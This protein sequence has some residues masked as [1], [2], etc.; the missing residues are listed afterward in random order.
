[1]VLDLSAGEKGRSAHFSPG[2]LTEQLWTPS[3]EGGGPEPGWASP[4]CHQQLQTEKTD[5]VWGVWVDRRGHRLEGVASEQNMRVGLLEKTAPGSFPGWNMF[6]LFMVLRGG[7]YSLINKWELISWRDSVWVGRSLCC[8]WMAESLFLESGRNL[9]W[10]QPTVLS[11]ASALQAAQGAAGTGNYMC[12]PTTNHHC[13]QGGLENIGF[14]HWAPEG[15][16]KKPHF[17]DK[18]W[19]ITSVPRHATLKPPTQTSWLK[20]GN[21]SNCTTI[22]ELSSAVAGTLNTSVMAMGTSAPGA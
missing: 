16:A 12:Q 15:L 8:F 18:T 14:F 10:F 6:Q 3:P 17:S 4:V 20:H 22:I 9:G 1:M 11:V 19:R 2:L 21:I 7:K 13:G 5:H